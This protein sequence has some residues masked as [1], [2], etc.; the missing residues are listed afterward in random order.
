MKTAKLI[1]GIISMVLFFLIAMQSCVAG[2]G[3][4]LQENGEVSG[5]AGI[6]LA[7]CMLIAGIISVAARKS[8]A[9][10]FVA[11]SF[12]AFGGLLGLT[13]AGSYSDLVIWSVVAFSFAVVMI[14]GSALAKPQK[15]EP[16]K[17]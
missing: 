7:L 8:K 6:C 12:Y 17:A 4:I 2:L 15:N 14:L 13:N 11:G 16:P 9:A 3:N 1:I 5:S 10:G